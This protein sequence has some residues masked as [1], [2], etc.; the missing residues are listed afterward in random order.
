MIIE[1]NDGWRDR[2][3]QGE[4]T[5]VEEKTSNAYPVLNFWRK[6]KVREKGQ[7]EI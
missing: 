6:L 7:A 4:K 5:D 1:S 2:E 3:M